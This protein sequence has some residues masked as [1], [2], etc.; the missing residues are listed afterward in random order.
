MAVEIPFLKQIYETLKSDRSDEDTVWDDI[1]TFIMPLT[2]KVSQAIEKSSPENKTNILLWDLTAPL[3]NEHLAAAL[4]SDVTSPASRWLDFEWEDAE[5]E[6]DHDAVVYR[7]KLSELVWSELQASDFNMEIASAYGEWSGIGNM[8]LVCEP[9]STGVEWKGL[10]FTAVPCRQVQF[11][12]NSR[13]GVHRWF[14]QLEWTALQI[15]DHCEREKNAD[16]T[17]KYAAPEKYKTMSEA[18]GQANQ[19][20]S[21]V[22]CVYRREGT[23]EE[24]QGRVVPELRPFGCVYFTL[25]DGVQLGEE[26][27]YYRMPAVMARWGKRPGT[28]WG[29]GRGHLA[30]RAVKG[31]NYFKELQLVAG[32]KAVDP[33]TGSTERVSNIDLR[34]GKTSVMPSKDDLWTIESSARFDVSAEIIRDDRIEIRRC[35]HEDDLQLKE[36]PQMTATEVQAR[37]DQMN[38]A[39]GSPVA[40]LQTDALQPIVMMVLDHLARAGKLPAPPEIVRRKKAE[41]KLRFRGPIARAQLLDEVVAIEREAGFIANLLKLGF[42]NARH[43]FNLGNAIKEHSKRLG[44]PASV[45]NSDQVAERAIKAEAAAMKAAQD[46]ETMKN[47]GQGAAAAAQAASLIGQGGIPIA[48]QPALVPSGGA[49]P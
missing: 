36:S 6:Q 21:V 19:K 47:A 13:G 30:L 35:F 7:E 32:E 49:L 14:R 37:K 24:V 45:L 34:P 29:Y 23:P 22:F 18:S 1:E 15:V 43:Y 38:R 17:P 44:V 8:A 5:V 16:G 28:Q 31:L 2:G 26:G 3:A 4:H 46:A 12:E 11:Q 42:T 20:V 39:M 48:E 25:E 41:V 33:A 10:D 9:M 27:G 40:R